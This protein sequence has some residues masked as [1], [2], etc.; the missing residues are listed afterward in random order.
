MNRVLSISLLIL[1]GMSVF[2]QQTVQFADSIRRVHGIPELSY[3]VVDI[4][5]TLE[6][7]ALGKHSINLPDTATLKDRFHI[8]SNT[9][10]MTAFMIAKYVEMGKLQWSTKFFEL[11]PEWKTKSNKAYS[12]ITLQD[13]LS[14]KAG[15]QP[16]QGENDPTIPDFKGTAKEKRWK[17]GKFVL[18]LDP[19]PLDSTSPFVYS[20]AG[21][22]LASMMLE[23]VA[24]KSWEQLVNKIFNEDLHLQ[25]G[26][27][28]PENQKRKDT[29]GHSFEN[30]QLIPIASN[31]GYHLDYTEPDGDINIKLKDYIKFIQLNLQGL[32]GKNNY[33]KASTYSF[34]HRGVKNY[35]MGWYNIYENNKELSTHA[36]TA[37]TYYTLVHIDRIKKIAYIIFTNAYSDNTSEGVR[38]LMRKLKENYVELK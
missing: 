6:I 20:N 24:N 35:S 25:V 23:K 7:A 34:L 32:S 33:L 18:T 17:F 1:N 31:K 14:H 19:I 37:F 21:Y 26:L 13:L 4:K 11:F 9:K 29:W 27:S 36:G 30:G 38:I 2:A 3:A 5:A 12:S 28:W 8:G 15:V 10:A 22:T 16:F